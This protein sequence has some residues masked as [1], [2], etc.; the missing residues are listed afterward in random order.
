[1]NIVIPMAGKGQRLYDAGYKVPKP[2]IEINGKMM[3]EWALQSLDFYDSSRD[4]LIFICLNEH[5]RQFKMDKKLNFF[6]PNCK[7]ILT[8][9]I[10]EGQACT[11]LLIKDLINNNVPLIIYNIDTYFKSDFG[12]KILDPANKFDGIIPIF[13]NNDPNYSYVKLGHDGYILEVAEKRTIA[14]NATVGLYFFTKGQYF[15]KAA[16]LMIQK[17]I[18]VNNEFYVGPCYN[19]LIAEG[20][21]FVIDEVEFV[22]DLGTP[23]GIEKFKKEYS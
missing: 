10:T 4:L 7:I 22:Y 12:K 15:V 23:D 6:Y 8:D 16:E 13:K 19:E 2:L 11:V 5:I 14:D 1:M 9:G 18:R 20:K 21:K 17:N 3:F